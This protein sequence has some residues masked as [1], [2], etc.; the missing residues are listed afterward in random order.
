MTRVLT[1]LVGNALRHTPPGGQ[2][3]L[4]VQAVAAQVQ[5]IVA[6]TGPGIAPEHLPNIFERFIAP[7]RRAR[8]PPAARGWAWPSSNRW[9]RLTAARWRWPAPPARARYSR[10]PCR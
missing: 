4:T 6:D 5:L 9:S 2:I 8:R 10:L 3:T 1:N 7:I